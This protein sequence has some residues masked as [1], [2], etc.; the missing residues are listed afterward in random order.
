MQIPQLRNINQDP[1]MS[2][3]FKYA[4]NEGKNIIGKKQGDYEPDIT[5]SGV[6][7]HK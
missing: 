6:G 1:A 3:M 5:I 2:G 4:M 7:I